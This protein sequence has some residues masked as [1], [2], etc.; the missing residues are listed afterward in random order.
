MDASFFGSSGGA[1]QLKFERTPIS[2][3]ELQ[4]KRVAGCARVTYRR[5]FPEVTGKS[6][7]GSQKHRLRPASELQRKGAAIIHCFAWGWGG[8]E[9]SSYLQSQHSGG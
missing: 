6:S 8:G 5:R 9:G 3:G 4:E 2:I 1:R 7:T